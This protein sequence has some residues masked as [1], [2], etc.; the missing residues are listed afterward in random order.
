VEPSLGNLARFVSDGP[1]Q[2][3]TDTFGSIAISRFESDDRAS[4]RLDPAFPALRKL[5]FA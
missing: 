2:P 5:G 1:R 3:C 4:S